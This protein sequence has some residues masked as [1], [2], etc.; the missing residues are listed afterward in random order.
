MPPFG[1]LNWLE[2]AWEQN[3]DNARAGKPDIIR[4]CPALAGEASTK[5]CMFS[6]RLAIG[7]KPTRPTLEAGGQRSPTA[8]VHACRS[9]QPFGGYDRG[10]SIPHEQNG[11]TGLTAGAIVFRRDSSLQAV[12][13]GR[14][15]VHQYRAAVVISLPWEEIRP[16]HQA[17]KS[18][19]VEA[20]LP[21]DRSYE[22]DISKAAFLG[23]QIVPVGYRVK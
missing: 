16:Q 20:H 4:S 6:Y 13:T 9:H 11:N 23:R 1:V 14:F 2:H 8:N 18:P 22:L 21:V 10:D 5:I 3:G 12:S 19:N 15:A 7:L 17:F